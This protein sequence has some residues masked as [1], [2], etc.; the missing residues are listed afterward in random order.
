[1]EID[2]EYIDLHSD[3][4]DF[5]LTGENAEENIQEKLEEHVFAWTVSDD[6]YTLRQILPYANVNDRDDGDL[7]EDNNYKDTEDH[8]VGNGN[9]TA[10]INSD[11]A[12]IYV[13]GTKYIV[14][15][16]TAFI[17]TDEKVL[18]TGFE[19][20]P[21]Y[22]DNDATDPVKFWAIDKNSD[23]AL[24]VVFVYSGEASNSNKTYF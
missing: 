22:V 20:V 7:Y 18:Y 23:G 6:V 9:N 17:D 19:N 10:A 12:F 21:D 5:V 14:D 4:Q 13:N 2:D 8:A 15:E 1:M 24:D 16:K 11:K 3:R